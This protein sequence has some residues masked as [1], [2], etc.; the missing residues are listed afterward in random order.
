[1]FNGGLPEKNDP[2]EILDVQP[3]AFKALMEWVVVGV[4]S[5]TSFCIFKKIVLIPQVHLH[6]QDQHQH[7]GQS[8]WSVLC[9]EKVHDSVCG[10]SVHEIFM[11]RSMSEECLSCIRICQFVRRASFS[12][13]MSAGLCEWFFIFTPTEWT[14]QLFR[15]TYGPFRLFAPK[16]WTFCRMPVLRTSIYRH[17]WPFWTK[18]ICILNR[19]WT[20]STQ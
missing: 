7:C 16:R 10:W 1:M 9:G 14:L 18:N 13:K 6:R 20:C 12:W 11:V 5:L 2:I 4:E 3:E 19:N 8:I 17:C 15:L